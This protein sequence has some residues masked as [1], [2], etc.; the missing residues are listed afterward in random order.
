ML[1][2]IASIFQPKVIQID[3]NDPQ[4]Y[5]D[6]AAVKKL[7]DFLLDQQKKTGVCPAIISSGKCGNEL[8]FRQSLVLDDEQSNP[9]MLTFFVMGEVINKTGTNSILHKINGILQA[10]MKNQRLVY[11]PDAQQARVAKVLYKIGNDNFDDQYQIGVKFSHLNMRKPIRNLSTGMVVLIMNMIKGVTSSDAYDYLAD[12]NDFSESM[13]FINSF[14][15]AYKKQI[16]DLGRIHGD[17]LSTEN[18]IYDFS[19]GKT[20]F[21]DFEHSVVRTEENYSDDI[22]GMIVMVNK[23]MDMIKGCDIE[24]SPENRQLVSRF[25]LLLKTILPDHESLNHSIMGLEKKLQTG[26]LTGDEIKALIAG[27]ASAMREYV[28]FTV[29][30]RFPNAGS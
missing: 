9:D 5:S 28:E 17:L 3:F 14:L 12:L 13:R 15:D 8:E 26:N 24:N 25:L 1:H 2:L 4:T 11:V 7:F 21:I 6:N 18:F 29:S 23:S 20:N 16:H 22:S 30:R 27:A 19:D 10:D